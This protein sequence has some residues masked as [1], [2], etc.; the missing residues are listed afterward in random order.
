MTPQPLYRRVLGEP[1]AAP[2]LRERHQP[3]PVENQVM[4]IFANATAREGANSHEEPR[5][6]GR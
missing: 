6:F 4:V 5:L 1:I 3:L 2:L